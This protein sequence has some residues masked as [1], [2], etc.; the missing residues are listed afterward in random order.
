V[1]RAVSGRAV[2]F[3]L[4]GEPAA[5]FSTLVDG[6]PTPARLAASPALETLIIPWAG[7]PLRTRDLLRSLRPG[8][9]VHNLHH[10]AGPTAEMAIALFLAAAKGIVPRDAELRRGDWSNRER[11]ELALGASGRR[12][13]VWGAGAIGH[14]VATICGAL[15]MDVELVGRSSR[16]G[17]HGQEELDRLLT[18]AEVLFV[19]VPLTPET[20]GR[21]G[22]AELARLPA[23]AILVNVARGRIVQE[24]ALYEALASRRLFAAGLDVWWRYPEGDAAETHPSGRPFRD[25]DNV[26]MSPHRAGHVQET[27]ELRMRALGECLRAL[28]EGR[29]APWPVDVE[30]GY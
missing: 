14:R 13:L 25:L 7:L 23:G 20:D 6:V 4:G 8:L 10:N 15:G 27:E 12:A 3:S 17:V 30:R 24:D 9:R 18:R 26:V 22:A 1:L 29:P 5:G 19:C 11:M 21:I 16:P 28:A 2:E